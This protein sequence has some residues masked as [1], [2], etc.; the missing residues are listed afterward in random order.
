MFVSLLVSGCATKYG[1]AN[2]INPLGYTDEKIGEGIYRLTYM[3]S[4]LEPRE[5]ASKYW[6]QRAT[7]L[8]GSSEFEHNEKLTVLNKPAFNPASLRHQDQ[9]FPFVEGTVTCRRK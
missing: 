9:Y 2:S 4:D 8:C 3:V 6:L 7:E 5:V 1:K